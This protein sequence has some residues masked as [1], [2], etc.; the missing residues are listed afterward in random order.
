MS[1][2]PFSTFTFRS[3]VIRKI[4]FSPSGSLKQQ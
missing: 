4:R 2:A 1:A 3:T